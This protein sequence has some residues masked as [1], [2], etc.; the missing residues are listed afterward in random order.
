MH[1][2]IL[3][4]QVVMKHELMND[5][6][7][8]ESTAWFAAEIKAL[9]SHYNEGS[10]LD[11]DQLGLELEVSSSWTPIFRSDKTTLA[12]V[13]SII[14]TIHRCSV[15]SIV[16]IRGKIVD[17]VY[18]YL[19]EVNDRMIENIRATLPQ[20]KNYVVTSSAFGKLIT[21]L[22]E[23]WRDMCLIPFLLSHKTRLLSD[24]WPGQTETDGKRIY[25][26][27]K[28]CAQLEIP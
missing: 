4:Y 13:R 19:K 23:Y 25:E 2:Y 18:V 6:E 7:M 20:M 10:I 28:S 3:F 1:S 9:P 24:S 5:D 21:S 22:I 15:Q 27:R 14:N 17:P 12:T 26:P 16:S 8:P 11:T